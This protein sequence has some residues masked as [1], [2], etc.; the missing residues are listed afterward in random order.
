MLEEQVNETPPMYMLVSFSSGKGI[1]FKIID[2]LI[3]V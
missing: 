2:L 1:K 3:N